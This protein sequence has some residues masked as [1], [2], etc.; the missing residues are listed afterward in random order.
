MK[1]IFTCGLSILFLCAKSQTISSVQIIPKPIYVKEEKG[2]YVLNN[3]TTIYYN[4]KA[5]RKA[6]FFANILRNATGYKLPLIKTNH[7]Q[8]KGINIFINQLGVSN[9]EA[10]QLLVKPGSVTLK[11]IDTLGLFNGFQSLLQ[12]LPASFIGKQ[13]KKTYWPIPAVEIKDAPRYTWR[14]YMLDVS[15]TFYGVAVIKKYLDVMALYKLNVF[16]LHL[17]DDQGWRIQIKSHP[18]LTSK[19]ATVFGETSNQPKERSGFYTQNQIKEI[20]DYAKERNIT[21]VPEIDVPGHCWP[22][23]ITNPNLGTNNTLKPD[24]VI[25]FMD[26]YSHWGF[27]FTPNPLDPTKEE[28]YTFLDDVFKEVAALFPGKYIHFGGDEVRHNFW[29][30][31]PSIQAFM[32]EKGF[33]K[34]EQLQSYFVTRV[35]KIITDNGKSPIGWNDI[36]EDAG[37]LP[38]T[39]AIMS[40]IGSDAV[41]NAAKY[42]FNVVATPTAPLYFDISQ[43]NVNDGTMVDWNY[44]GGDGKNGGGNTIKKVYD[45]NPERGLSQNEKK[46]LLGVQANMWPAVAQ[47]VKDLN[48]QNFPRLLAVAEIG[49]TSSEN[50]DYDNFLVRLNNNYSRLDALH[51]DYFRKGGYIVNT[52][53]SAQIT[54]DFKT[55]QWDV[56]P[57]VYTNGRCQAGFLFTGGTSFLKV[58]NVKLLEDGKEIATDGHESLADKF[59]GTPFKKNMFFYILNV[60]NYNPKAKYTLQA[61]I[62]GKDSSDSK[63]NITFNLSPYKPFI[64]TKK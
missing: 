47:E 46:Y 28:V 30:Q 7:V 9:K 12:L 22:I 26:S 61:D 20:V 48:I 39:T 4:E 62:A 25:S 36:L 57:Q 17:T 44:G 29:E 49:W 13:S 53:N 38:K 54:T 52:W 34:I 21:I 6:Q 63:G 32:K 56:T 55:I 27:Q 16:H 60:D 14:G 18:E 33:T 58:K 64:E 19:K 3:K 2:Q 50:K 42:G 8:Q 5:F 45:Y 24:H 11:S 35:S 10:Y 31:S 37:S 15:R 40:W 59:R 1:K 43:D 41:K 51:I 23:V